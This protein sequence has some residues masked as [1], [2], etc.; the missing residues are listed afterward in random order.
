MELNCNYLFLILKL[1]LSLIPSA[2]PPWRSTL[3]D[4]WN[5]GR[6]NGWGHMPEKLRVEPS[7]RVELSKNSW[8]HHSGERELCLLGVL[9]SIQ[10]P[11]LWCFGLLALLRHPGELEVA[12]AQFPALPSSPAL[13][14]HRWDW[15]LLHAEEG[16]CL[17]SCRAVR[18][19]QV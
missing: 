13:K 9:K 17:W 10:D 5:G 4:R 15:V 3:E 11:R 7:Q 16:T 18:G 1:G 2:S 19:S 12:M 6:I 8:G 14:V